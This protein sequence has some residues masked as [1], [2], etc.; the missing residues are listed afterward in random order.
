MALAAIEDLVL[1]S[2]DI[3]HAFTNSDIDAEIYMIQPEGFK[4]GGSKYV[5]K[6]NK[7]LYGLKQSP[8]LWGEKPADVRGRRMLEA[9]LI[10]RW[11]IF[12]FP[13]SLYTTMRL[14]EGCTNLY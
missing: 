5:C 1:Q 8:H 4:Q 3:S 14:Y 7:S 11:G 12:N 9:N 10:T 13:P 2:V 6:L